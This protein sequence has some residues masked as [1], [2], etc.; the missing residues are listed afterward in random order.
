MYFLC[1]CFILSQFFFLHEFCFDFGWLRYYFVCA[2][3][4][5]LC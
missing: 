3:A 2:C 4:L 1:V 5:L